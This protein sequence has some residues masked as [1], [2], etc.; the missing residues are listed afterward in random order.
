MNGI[1]GRFEEVKESY[2][3]TLNSEFLKNYVIE[4]YKKTINYR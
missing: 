2:N 4:L 3:K 1:A